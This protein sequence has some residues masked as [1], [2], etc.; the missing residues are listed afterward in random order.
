MRY[1]LVLFDEY[2]D[3]RDERAAKQALRHCD[4]FIAVGTSGVVFPA[5]SYVREADFAGA[6]TVFVNIEAP[7]PPNPYFDDVVLGRA[8]EVLPALLEVS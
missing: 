8:E 6:R 5:A 7:S 1:D 3:P 4:W 2:L